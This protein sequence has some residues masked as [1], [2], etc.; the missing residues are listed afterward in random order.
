MESSEIE[1]F[2]KI[3]VMYH[4]DIELRFLTFFKFLKL[5]STEYDLDKTMFDIARGLSRHSKYVVRDGITQICSFQNIVYYGIDRYI[6]NI[7]RCCI[8]GLHDEC[9]R[10]VNSLYNIIQSIYVIRDTIV[11]NIKNMYNYDHYVNYVY[12][13]L[14]DLLFKINQEKAVDF[15]LN[16][17]KYNYKPLDM[18]C[19]KMIHRYNDDFNEY[20]TLN[21]LDVTL[22]YFVRMYVPADKY[23]DFLSADMKKRNTKEKTIK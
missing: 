4:L 19:L 12:Y 14:N 20:F 13:F 7:S 1:E 9:V 16:E 17:N 11:N 6:S 5:V 3:M 15:C 10:I 21:V 18:I 23:D 22:D 8:N 2:E